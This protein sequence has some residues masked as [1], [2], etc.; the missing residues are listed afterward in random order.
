M[1]RL[2]I[3]LVVLLVLFGG[4]SACT[5][6]DE[7]K[8]FTIEELAQFDGTGGKAAYAAIDGVVYD[9]SDVA[10]WADGQHFGL[11]AGHDWS[12]EIE[13]M[14]PHGKDVLKDLPVVG[15]LK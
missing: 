9:V 6:K 2:S 4:L 5:K 3:V 8:T 7:E 11:T 12:V 1:K 10:S 13:E 14:S 15:K